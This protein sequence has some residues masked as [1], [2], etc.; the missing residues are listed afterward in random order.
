MTMAVTDSI[1]IL[2]ADALAAGLSAAEFDGEFSEIAARRVYVPD[3]QAAD[4][5]ELHVSVVPGSCEITPMTHGGDMYEMEIHVVLAKR[6][7][8]D[9][10]LDFLVELRTQIANLIRSGQVPAA[11]PAM[12]ADT[13]WITINNE[14]TFDR[15]ALTGH[16]IFLSDMVV[17][18]RRLQAKAT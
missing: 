7:T 5:G 16:R 10:E 8:S 17:T 11:V 3:Y 6:F 12:P 13:K 1:E 15:D 2:V 14:T 9:D 4:V 18:Y